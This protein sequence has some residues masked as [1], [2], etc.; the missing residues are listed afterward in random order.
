MTWDRT[1]ETVA[2]RYLG[3]TVSGVI[4][5]SRV[6]YGGAVQ[7]TL[8]LDPPRRLFGSLRRVVLM[9]EGDLF[10]TGRQPA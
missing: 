8:Q 3:H 1:G 4:R 5:E 7:H 10:N 6:K 2:G 9:D